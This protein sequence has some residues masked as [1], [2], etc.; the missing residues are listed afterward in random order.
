MSKIKVLIVDDHPMLRNGLVAL[1]NEQEDMIVVGEASNGSEAVNQV[2]ECHPDLVL[3]DVNMDGSV[4]VTSTQLIT[5]QHPDTKVLAFSMHHEAHIVKNMLEAGASGYLLKSVGHEEVI[6]GIRKVASG[7]NY[8]CEEVL[9]LI[10]DILTGNSDVGKQVKLSKRETE[11]LSFVAR[12]FS[13]LEISEKLSM[14]QRTV[15]THK[16]NLIKK[17]GVRNVVGLVLYAMENGYLS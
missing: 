16:R 6:T 10:I 2:E 9:D 7:E 14:S 12:E 5:S 17:L 11:V 4:D 3:M 1:V 15:E 13:N 8:Y